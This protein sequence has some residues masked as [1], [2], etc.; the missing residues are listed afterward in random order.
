MH[1][2]APLEGFSHIISYAQSGRWASLV[3]NGDIAACWWEYPSEAG[4]QAVEWETAAVPATATE[5]PVTFAWTCVLGNGT[6]PYPHHLHLNGEE[7]VAFETPLRRKTTWTG[8]GCAL[9]FECFG[10]AQNGEAH[11]VMSLTVP[12]SRVTPG[13]S[14]RLKAV[15]GRTQAPNMSFFNLLSFTDTVIH[16]REVEQGRME[17]AAAGHPKAVILLSPKASHVEEFAARELQRYI[18]RISGARLTVKTTPGKRDTNALYIGTPGTMPKACPSADLP[19]LDPAEDAI[20]VKNVD[21]GVAIVGSNPRSTLSAV[22]QFLRSLGC[23]W[24]EPGPYGEVIHRSSTIRIGE[25]NIHEIASFKIRTSRPTEDIYIYSRKDI[26]DQID[27]M[28]K[29]R[30]NWFQFLIPP[31]ERLKST[32][33]SEMRKRG[34]VINV[35]IHNFRAWIPNELYETHPEYFAEIGGKRMPRGTI[36]CASNKEA[37]AL[38]AENAAAWAKRHPEIDEIAISCDDGSA[39]CQCPGCRALRPVEQL[40]IFYNAAARAIHKVFP[41]KKIMVCS[42]GRHYEPSRGIRPYTKNV[43]VELDTFVRCQGHPLNSVECSKENTQAGDSYDTADVRTPHMNRY[44]CLCLR[45]WMD[46]FG[47]V[48][49]FE[50]V[51]LHGR[52]STPFPYPHVLAADLRYY[53]DI[54]VA[55]FS[56]Q[57]DLV[58][59]APSALDLYVVARLSWN[60]EL[61]LEQVLDDFFEGYYGRAAGP[62][63]RYFALL[64]QRLAG[65]HTHTVLS[66]LTANDLKRCVVY[67]EQAKRLAGTHAA[68]N[69]VRRSRVVFEHTRMLWELQQARDRVRELIGQARTKEARRGRAEAVS[70]AGRWARFA[71][72]HMHEN[73]ILFTKDSGTAFLE[74]CLNAYPEAVASP[75]VAIRELLKDAASFATIEDVARSIKARRQAQKG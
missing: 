18:E 5:N 40:Q 60:V 9:R 67:L 14:V 51:M 21:K 73:L 1:R 59:W 6:G 50:N 47:E 23:E 16:Q 19:E 25:L 10:R 15:G 31:F 54:G 48:N 29:N 22:Y 4:N 74:D 43:A 32:I 63:R 39:Y 58:R 66:V 38:W 53:K 3:R 55:G 45:K 46:T 34:M 36:R 27:W 20:A 71:Q 65:Q 64:E 26:R 75:K 72:R 44:L 24:F 35:G 33:V 11:G 12:A 13:E 7:V 68:R 49:V 2:D 41:G 30:M 8:R 42:Y 61:S 70:L 69:V 17:I 28:A 37:V 56:P 57:A 62:M 52:Q